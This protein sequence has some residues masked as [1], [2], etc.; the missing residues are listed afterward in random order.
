MT[1]KQIEEEF[2]KEFV[3]PKDYFDEKIMGKYKPDVWGKYRQNPDLI[4]QFYR[5]KIKEWVLE[6]VGEDEKIENHHE[7][8]YS[9]CPR[10]CEIKATN[11]AKVEIRKRIN[12]EFS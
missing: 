11:Q 8:Y 12:K 3:I 5:Q 4:K 2:D 1:Y 7:K 10:C 6:I 9:E